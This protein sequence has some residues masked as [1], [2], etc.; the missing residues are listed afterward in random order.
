MNFFNVHSKGNRISD[1]KGLNI[2]ILEGKAKMLKDKGYEDK[3]LS[4]VFVQKTSPEESLFL[5][6]GQT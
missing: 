2:E 4:L 6:L 5:R 1:G 3:D